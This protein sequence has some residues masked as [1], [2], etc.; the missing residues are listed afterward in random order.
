MQN[1]QN[2]IRNGGVCGRR[3][4]FGRFLLR[5]FGIPTW[6]V[7]QHKHAALSHWT[8]KG[9]VVNLGA[10]FEHSWWDKDEAPRSGSDFLLETQA[11]AHPQDSR[12]A[13]AG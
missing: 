2:I 7:T 3:A 5:A 13:A 9:W 4:F 11:R 10:G 6:G 1:Y 8:P 12:R